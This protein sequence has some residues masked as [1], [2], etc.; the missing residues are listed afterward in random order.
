M[1]AGAAVRG[2]QSG[3][4]GPPCVPPL[5]TP[6]TS[7]C[8][9]FATSHRVVQFLS[10]H[11]TCLMPPQPYPMP[12]TRRRVGGGSHLCTLRSN[13]HVHSTSGH[14][15]GWAGCLYAESRLWGAG[16]VPERLSRDSSRGASFCS[17]PTADLQAGPC[18]L[19]NPPAR[20]PGT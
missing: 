10:P 11:V 17:E 13:G 7:H 19:S 1:I 14:L 16:H 12:H 6:T 3:T 4:S 2:D 18:G 5:S 20:H 9:N 15:I 8:A